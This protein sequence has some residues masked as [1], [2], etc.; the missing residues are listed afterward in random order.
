M[1]E[2]DLRVGRGTDAEGL[3]DGG[4]ATDAV[5]RR[6]HSLRSS[7]KASVGWGLTHGSKLLIASR[8]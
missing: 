5:L 6:R 3:S 2:E 1:R 4:G 7:L 8:L